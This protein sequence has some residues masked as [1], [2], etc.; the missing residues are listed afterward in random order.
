MKLNYYN[1]IKS[2]TEPY[3]YSIH[4]DVGDYNENIEL[5]SKEDNCSISEKLNEIFEDL[6]GT[7][8]H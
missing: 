7:T 4:S 8:K 5:I 6:D 2:N 1:Y 3:T